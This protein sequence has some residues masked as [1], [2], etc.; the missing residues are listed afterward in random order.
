MR[1]TLANSHLRKKSVLSKADSSN[2]THS[3]QSRHN[4]TSETSYLL[5]LEFFYTTP[6]RAFEDSSRGKTANNR[7][8]IVVSTTQETD[9]RF[10]SNLLSNLL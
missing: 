9:I 8:K 2:H 5:S 4:R 3:N 7:A 6:T 10:I 1:I